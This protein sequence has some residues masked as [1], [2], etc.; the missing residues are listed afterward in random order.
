MGGSREGKDEVPGDRREVRMSYGS[1]RGK[2]EG[3]A[4]VPG[5]NGSPA[6]LGGGEQRGS[7]SLQS[8]GPHPAILQGGCDTGEAAKKGQS[9][10]QL[11]R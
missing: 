3:P 1:Q 10:L 4:W 2:A 9:Y 8:E 5:L 7:K 11:H 6:F